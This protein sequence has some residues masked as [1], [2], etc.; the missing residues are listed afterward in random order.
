MNQTE[1]SLTSPMPERRGAACKKPVFA[2]K[3]AL[4]LGPC[5]GLELDRVSSY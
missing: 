2:F 5:K 4:F 3:G 1:P